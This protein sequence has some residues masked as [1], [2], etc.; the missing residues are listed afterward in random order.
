MCLYNA[1]QGMEME[2]QLRFHKFGIITAKRSENLSRRNVVRELE[3][4]ERVC[5]FLGVWSAVEIYQRRTWFVGKYMIDK[6]WIMSGLNG[7]VAMVD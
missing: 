1:V 7:R 4:V 5:F 3:K 2:W 6:I